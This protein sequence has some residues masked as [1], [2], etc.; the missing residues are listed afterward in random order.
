[1]V[2]ECGITRM[3]TDGH[4]QARRE[5]VVGRIGHIRRIG[6]GSGELLI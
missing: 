6:R 2:G 1:M 3:D 5:E 4:G